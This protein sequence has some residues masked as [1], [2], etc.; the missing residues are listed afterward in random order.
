MSIALKL[1]ESIGGFFYILDNF[2]TNYARRPLIS[3][4]LP[5]LFPGIFRSRAVVWQNDL[6]SHPSKP[7]YTVDKN[8]NLRDSQRLVAMRGQFFRASSSYH[9]DQL[10]PDSQCVVDIWPLES[11]K[12]TSI[13]SLVTAT[14]V[15]DVEIFPSVTLLHGSH[16]LLF[17]ARCQR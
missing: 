14:T 3:A 1:H 15:G 2:T 17:F 10:P 11:L 13:R 12:K 9:G 4:H 8:T 7:G 16:L 6:R 5:G